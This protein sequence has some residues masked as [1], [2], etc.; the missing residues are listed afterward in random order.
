MC[1]EG[2]GALYMCVEDLAYCVRAQE[3]AARLRGAH[4][5]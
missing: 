1:V 5:V 2:K 3:C 4:A